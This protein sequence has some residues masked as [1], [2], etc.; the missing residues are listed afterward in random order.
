[1]KRFV[2]LVLV[3]L[4]FSAL[5]FAQTGVFN[6]SGRAT[7][8]M[9]TRGFS[10]A[11]NFI[12]LNSTIRVV[13]TTNREE[14]DVTVTGRIPPSSDRIVDLS[15]DAWEA[16]KLDSENVVLLLFLPPPVVETDQHGIR[17]SVDGQ[18]S[19]Y[20]A[21]G[22]EAPVNITIYNYVTNPNRAA[23]APVLPQE[24][25]RT[26]VE[27]APCTRSAPVPFNEMVI[28]PSLPD[29][30]TNKVYRLQV[31]SYAMPEAAN[32]T[33]Q[34]V[35]DA[36]FRSAQERHGSMNRV[37]AMGIRAA[38]VRSAVQRL[39]AAGFKEVWIRE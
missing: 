18:E 37:L 9:T 34:C 36:G 6:Q 7:Q 21:D 27:E 32:I 8:E 23:Q 24:G 25:E 19:E 11:H 28:I 3:G 38:D 26:G 5:A 29:P 31:G 15:Y 35:R 4:L 17:V 12:P 1:M 30:N 14:I 39:G 13:N 10:A 33:E 16:L 2:L 22:D 20:Y